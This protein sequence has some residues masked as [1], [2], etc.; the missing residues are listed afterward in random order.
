MRPETEA[1]SGQSPSQTSFAGKKA[2]IIALNFIIGA[3]LILTGYFGH[4]FFDRYFTRHQPQ[5]QQPVE[6]QQEPPP[7]AQVVQIDVLNG[8]GEKG[9]GARFT[10]F[11]RARGYDVVEM[12]NYKTQNMP[13]TL[14]IDRVGNLKPARDIA[15]HLGVAD[16]NILQQLNP[17]YFV[18]VSVVIGEDFYDLSPSKEKK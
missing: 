2:V 6:Q 17:D 9:V 14:I 8:C 13:H 15:V 12:K 10:N 16:T 3:M 5:T 7:P 18:D 11:L 4:N 1:N